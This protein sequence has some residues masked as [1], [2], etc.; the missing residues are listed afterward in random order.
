MQDL[1]VLAAPYNG[2]SLGEAINN[3]GQVAGFSIPPNSNIGHAFLYSN[4]T[5]SRPQDFRRQALVLR[6]LSTIADN[7]FV[8]FRTLTPFSIAMEQWQTLAP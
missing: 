5:M 7:D 6:T 1:G 2:S 8:A 3:N 4:G